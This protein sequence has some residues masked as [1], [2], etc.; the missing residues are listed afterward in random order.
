[1]KVVILLQTDGFPTILFFPAGNKS[2]DPVGASPF[3]SSSLFFNLIYIV[4]IWFNLPVS[5]SRA[6]PQ[7]WRDFVIWYLSFWGSADNIWWWP[8]FGDIL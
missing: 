8:D 6:G 3:S 5:I 4:P 1:M 7:A 2:F